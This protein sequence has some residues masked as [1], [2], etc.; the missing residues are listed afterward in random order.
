M[1]LRSFGTIT[2]KKHYN[3]VNVLTETVKRGRTLWKERYNLINV[4]MEAV[5]QV[6]YWLCISSQNHTKVWFEHAKKTEIKI[7]NYY[8]VKNYKVK[9]EVIFFALVTFFN[10]VC[11][12]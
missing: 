2:M 3:L 12:I 11:Q 4:L 6:W 10:V 9:S 8:I 1:I 7:I 5:D